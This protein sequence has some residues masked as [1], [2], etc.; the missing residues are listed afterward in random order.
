MTKIR[1]NTLSWQHKQINTIN[2]D[3]VTLGMCGFSAITGNI[4]TE[5][6]SAVGNV[7]SVRTALTLTVTDA[8]NSPNTVLL[9]ISVTLLLMLSAALSIGTLCIC[10]HIALYIFFRTNTMYTDPK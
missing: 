8:L 9:S 6:I 2:K 4:D 3:I 1:K 10:A 5:V 7:K